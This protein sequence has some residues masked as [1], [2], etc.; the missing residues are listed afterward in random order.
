MARKERDEELSVISIEMV[1]DR[2]AG[3]KGAEWSSVQ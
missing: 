1:T 3:D 2:G